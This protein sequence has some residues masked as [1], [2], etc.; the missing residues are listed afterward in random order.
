MA[1][2]I[3]CLPAIK[4]GKLDK[5][6][7]LHDEMDLPPSIVSCIHNKASVIIA[8]L[9]DAVRQSIRSLLFRI[10]VCLSGASSFSYVSYQIEIWCQALV[11][12]FLQQQWRNNIANDGGRSHFITE[13]PILIQF[14][15][16][17]HWG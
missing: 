11:L 9:L 5:N 7:R 10:I 14:A 15:H 17:E 13:L 8:P 12:Y 3:G 2:W 1:G 6:G 4:M 16:F